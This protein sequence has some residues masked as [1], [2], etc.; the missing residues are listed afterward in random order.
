MIQ[1]RNDLLAAYPL[2]GRNDVLSV[3]V[4]GDQRNDV[5]SV[6]N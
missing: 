4:L 1:K 3:V 2:P 6:E 5:R